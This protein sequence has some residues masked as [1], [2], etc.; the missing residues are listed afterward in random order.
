[1]TT[2]RS[3]PVPGAAG[4]M[5]GR[6]CS[7]YKQN[8]TKAHRSKTS[9]H[10]RPTRLGTAAWSVVAKVARRMDPKEWESDQ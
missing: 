9:S 2:R 1:M 7:S 10:Y 4:T 5:D 3:R 8:N 6:T